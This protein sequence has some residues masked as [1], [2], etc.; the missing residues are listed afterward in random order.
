MNLIDGSSIWMTSIMDMLSRESNIHLSVLLKR[1]IIRTILLEPFVIS[2]KV[3]LIN[4]W[5]YSFSQQVNAA[6]YKRERLLPKDAVEMIENLDCEEDYDIL[7]LRGFNV[8]KEISMRSELALKTW[9]YITDF[10][11]NENS[12]TQEQRNDLIKIYEKAK[13][14]V[15]QTKQL[16]QYFKKIVGHGTDKFILLP[17][18][19]PD[20]KLQEPHFSN[21]SD[22]LVYVGKFAFQWNISE[23]ID[24]FVKLK[25]KNEKIEYHIAGDKFNRD[26]NN[27]NFEN[28]LKYKLENTEGV[29]WH[30]A[31]MKEEIEDLIDKC[32]LGISWRHAELDESLEISTKLLEYGRLGKPVIMN[33]NTIHEE[34]FG[35]DYPL[36]ANT[37]CELIE[38]VEKALSCSEIY[39]N[40]AEILYEACKSFTIS[41]A[42]AKLKNCLW[43]G[44]TKTLDNR[45]KIFISEHYSKLIPILE[46]Y[47]RTV[48]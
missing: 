42:Y 43:D 28:E 34:L 3:K 48:K 18:L 17:P 11:Q 26:P 47:L 1:P 14:I 29:I 41:K 40:A 13:Y 10:P 38:Q 31:M 33:R 7:I 16:E 20:Y 21:K 6:W 32:D 23:S 22:R 12:V 39:K 27:I 4:P 37:E 46:S 36:Y 5:T 30:K 35:K 24:A 25:K 9:T 15:C 19:I 8:C 2:G 44:I 45:N